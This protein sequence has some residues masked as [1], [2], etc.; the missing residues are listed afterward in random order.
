LK[1]GPTV[2]GHRDGVQFKAKGL[3]VVGDVD[4]ERC[5]DLSQQRADAT[6]R[7]L[8]CFGLEEGVGV[9]EAELVFDLEDIAARERPTCSRNAG[10]P[11]MVLIS[12]AQH[13]PE[14]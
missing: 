1:I 4:E 6:V 11:N 7:F 14:R 10:L 5:F 8:S 12:R 9:L 2:S 13:D 3:N